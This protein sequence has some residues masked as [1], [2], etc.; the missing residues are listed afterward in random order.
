MLRLLLAMWLQGAFVVE[1]STVGVNGETI[2]LH[3][4]ANMEERRHI[5]IYIYVYMWTRRLTRMGAHRRHMDEMTRQV[6]DQF[7]HAVKDKKALIEEVAALR[8]LVGNGGGGSSSRR[9]SPALPP[10]C[11]CVCVYICICIYVYIYINI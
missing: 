5:Y 10:I 2:K 8:A 1:S 4:H 3:P 11:M 9:F 6:R 7:M